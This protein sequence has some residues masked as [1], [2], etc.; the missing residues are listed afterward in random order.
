MTVV[1]SLDVR[2]QPELVLFMQILVCKTWASDSGKFW[3]FAR[4]HHSTCLLSAQSREASQGRPVLPLIPR[5]SLRVRLLEKERSQCLWHRFLG[6][7]SESIMGWGQ[8]PGLTHHT[9]QL[10]PSRRGASAT[11]ATCST[12]H[13]VCPE[14]SRL[15]GGGAAEKVGPAPGWRT[16]PAPEL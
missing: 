16:L 5:P 14:W 3:A 8:V 9:F 15:R 13:L 1:K 7:L 10:L 2:N 6:E 4:H 11:P 12:S